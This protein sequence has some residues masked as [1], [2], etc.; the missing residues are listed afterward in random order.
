MPESLAGVTPPARARAYLVSMD[1]RLAL[2]RH[3]DLLLAVVLA[4]TMTAELLARSGGAAR[5]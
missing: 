1:L 5:W 2:R 4:G 3:G